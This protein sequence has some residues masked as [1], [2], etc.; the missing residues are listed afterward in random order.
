MSHIPEVVDSLTCVNT[1]N[2][3]PQCRINQRISFTGKAHIYITFDISYT[4]ELDSGVLDPEEHY[5][6][7]LTDKSK[8][9]FL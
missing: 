2:V 1:S 8:T 6:K 4:N 9:Y 5:W 3:K 7:T